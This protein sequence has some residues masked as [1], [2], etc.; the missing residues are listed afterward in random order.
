M[1]CFDFMTPIIYLKGKAMKNITRLYGFKGQISSR[2]KHIKK[3]VFTKFHRLGKVE[4]NRIYNSFIESFFNIDLKLNYSKEKICQS[5]LHVNNP[6]LTSEKIGIEELFD[7]KR[8]RISG[9]EVLIIVREGV[10]IQKD[11]ST[12]KGKII[13]VRREELGV[14]ASP[15]L[16][17]SF[18]CF[19]NDLG[20][21]RQSIGFYFENLKNRFTSSS[22]RPMHKKNFSLQRLF[23]S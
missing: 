2:Y 12:R 1:K 14:L 21:L 5:S 18:K 11:F 10:I 4:E 19:N 16:N 17:N 6:S 8:R 9:R 22:L 13:T 15:L 23:F 20:K 7:W 3:N